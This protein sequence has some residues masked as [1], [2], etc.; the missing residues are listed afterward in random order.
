MGPNLTAIGSAAQP[1]YFLEALLEP[2]KS[3]KE[4]YGSLVVVTTD[5]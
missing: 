2:G 1:D 3:V 5:G 4:S